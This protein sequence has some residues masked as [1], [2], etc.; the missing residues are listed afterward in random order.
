MG[1]VCQINFVFT[2]FIF[3]LVNHMIITVISHN[4]FG[5][6]WTELNLPNVIH[7][8]NQN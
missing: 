4:D 6:I 2:F 1:C 7:V 5:F 3:V 8:T